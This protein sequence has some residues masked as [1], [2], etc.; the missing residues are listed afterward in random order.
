MEQNKNTNLNVLDYALTDKGTPLKVKT[1]DNEGHPVWSYLANGDDVFTIDENGRYRYRGGVI[2]VQV[3]GFPM[4]E[5][6]TFYDNVA[7]VDVPA[8]IKYDPITVALPFKKL[9][10]ADKITTNGIYRPED[11]G[12][13]P[14]GHDYKGFDVVEV[15]IP[16]LTPSPKT[17]RENIAND[18]APSGFYYSP[19]TVAL[20]FQDLTGPN[21]ITTNGTYAASGLDGDGYPYQA[22]SQIEVDVQPVL[23][24]L[25]GANKVTVNG[26]LD[27]DDYPGFDGFG[28]IE[29]DIPIPP[30]ETKAP[31]PVADWDSNNYVWNL[32]D[33]NNNL[34]YALQSGDLTMTPAYNML[35]IG[36]GIGYNTNHT[37]K[38]VA[39]KAYNPNYFG[40]LSDRRVLS[41]CEKLTTTSD[42]QTATTDILS[43]GQWYSLFNLDI[44][45]I[46][47]QDAFASQ[48]DRDDF[49]DENTNIHG[50][51]KFKLTANVD[52][53][54]IA[55]LTNPTDRF[56]IISLEPAKD[57]HGND[58]GYFVDGNHMFGKL[59]C[60]LLIIRIPLAS[61]RPST[62]GTGN[63][64]NWA[65]F[66]DINDA[67]TTIY[68]Q[69]D[70]TDIDTSSNA[71]MF[72]TID[73][74]GLTKVYVDEGTLT[75]W[76]TV[77]TN[78]YA[79]L[80]ML[81]EI[82]SN[83]YLFLDNDIINSVLFNPTY[84]Y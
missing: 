27:I 24:D 78:N 83:S 62:P 67:T 26:T 63:V 45:A 20:P 76:Q 39:I 60:K 16:V 21:K 48:Q 42:A 8:D 47:L 4:T 49:F 14:D 32:R 53:P 23:K 30:P 59:Q 35:D 81:E 55:G 6:Y 56:E 51:L 19:I 80:G 12:Q 41:Y 2:Q 65:K 46:D 57:F 84:T 22:I 66:D 29:V 25:T 70:P 28:E 40:E 1:Y 52:G 11:Y 38:L 77:F 34:V 15:D 37:G 18:E 13:D 9:I 58:F 43:Y 68:L 79:V 50:R 73:A 64:I 33:G 31:V 54:F 82:P 36:S 61:E 69:G 74:S 71:D 44:S 3:D 17:Y 10:N 5:P 7:N 72:A 75:D